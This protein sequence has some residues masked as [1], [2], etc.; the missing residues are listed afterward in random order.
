MGYVDRPP[1]TL[2]LGCLPAAI[3]GLVVGLPAAFVA[4]MGECVDESGR[5][6]N[7]PNERLLLLAI[8]AVTASLCLLITWAT[9]RLVGVVTA[10]GHGAAWGVAG[11][12]ALA[13]ALVMMLYLL[14][15]ALA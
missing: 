4:L 7:C 6:G 13:A 12:F 3:F 2:S 11:A 14:L 8:V 5:V 15:V 1:P 10:R 9:N